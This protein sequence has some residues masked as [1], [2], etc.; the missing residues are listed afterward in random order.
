MGI[1]AYQVIWQAQGTD[2]LPHHAD[3]FA[4]YFI[5]GC[6][7]PLVV[8]LTIPGLS[9]WTDD[10]MAS[11]CCQG[12]YPTA[13]ILLVALNKSHFE[14][15]TS[16]DIVT[17]HLSFQRPTSLEDS[18]CE[19]FE[20]LPIPSVRQPGHAQ[21]R[22]YPVP[23]AASTTASTLVRYE[24]LARMALE[25]DS[26]ERSALHVPISASSSTQNVR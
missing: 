16:G 10:D 20:E 3:A 26:E 18:S 21:E 6:L 22:W 8:S 14:G 24:E 11:R 2:Q 17:S 12:M 19:T 1:V 4:D 25:V 15:T 13:I 9:L 7:I 5:M 23:S